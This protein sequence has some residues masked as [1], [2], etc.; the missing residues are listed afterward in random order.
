MTIDFVQKYSGVPLNLNERKG[1]DLIH[2]YS[3]VNFGS[4]RC[5]IRSIGTTSDYCLMFSGYIGGQR[6]STMLPDDFMPD[7]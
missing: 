7:D 5:I 1:T 2:H 4:K 6:V 3:E